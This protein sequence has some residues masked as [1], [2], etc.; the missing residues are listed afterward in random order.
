LGQDRLDAIR[1]MV[2]AFEEYDVESEC[3][4][5]CRQLLADMEAGDFTSYLE[6]EVK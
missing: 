4:E 5:R 2:A 6:S 3:V 1:G